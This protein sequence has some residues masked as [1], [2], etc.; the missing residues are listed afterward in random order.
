MSNSDSNREQERIVAELLERLGRDELVDIDALVAEHP[1]CAADL[2]RAHSDWICVQEGLIR[3]PEQDPE[4]T[5]GSVVEMLLD[6]LAARSL[7]DSRY[8]LRGELG[9]G[10]M[11]AV[12]EVWDRDLHRSLAMKVIRHAGVVR[13]SAQ[14]ARIPADRVARFIEE[15]QVSSQLSHPSV[16]P[17]HDLG[18]DAE[19]RLYFTMPIIEGRTFGSILETVHSEQSD[20]SQT[21]ALG[22]IVRTC[23]AMA[24][25]HSRGV[26][27][28]D[29]KPANLMIGPFG[30]T[31]VMDWGLAL[32]KQ[33]EHRPV[34]SERRKQIDSEP[35]SPLLTAT[36]FALG[37]A[38]YMPPEQVDGRHDTIDKPADIYAIGAMLYEL[39]TGT[40]PYLDDQDLQ[41]QSDV[42][43]AVQFGPPTPVRKLRRDVAE[44][45]ESICERAMAR[46]PSRRYPSMDS[47]AAD[48]NAYLENRVVQAHATGPLAEFRKW[49]GRNRAVALTA[50]ALL[51]VMLAAGFGQAW[52]ERRAKEAIA[53][54][55]DKADSA[56]LTGLR[57]EVSVLGPV[58]DDSVP[59]MERWLGQAR[60]LVA[61]RAQH[62]ATLESLRADR[63]AD[64]DHQDR[65]RD[66]WIARLERFLVELD[67]FTGEATGGSTIRTVEYRLEHARQLSERSLEAPRDAW[68]EAI[69]MISDPKVC[70]QYGR[71]QLKP[72]LGL[73]PIGRDPDS[74]LFEFWQV[75]SGAQPAR[76]PEG[77]L[78]IE[79][80]SGLVL[81]LIPGGSVWIGTQTAYPDEPNYDPD[82]V[83]DGD[84]GIYVPTLVTLDPFFLSKYEMTQGQWRLWAGLNP[85]YYQ[86]SESFENNG[87]HFGQT[88]PVETVSWEQALQ[89]LQL[90]GLTLPTEGQWEFACR[91][92]KQ[93]PWWCGDQKECLEGAVNLIDQTSA[94][95]G[96]DNA[97]RQEW[98]ELNDGYATTAPVDSL[99][100]NPLGLHH[101][102]GNVFEWTRESG[103]FLY[104]DAAP[105]D[106]DGLVPGELSNK[107]VIRGGSFRYSVRHAT[108]ARRGVLPPFDR[109][110]HT[111]VRP[112]RPV[113]H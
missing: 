51:I 61:R 84:P 82:A 15:A 22:V 52:Q 28:R 55:R 86:E 68:S 25:A 42:L 91:A 6:R 66:W 5:A 27:H 101:M 78:Q 46:E 79:S 35:Q 73:V 9:R 2:R 30:E 37:S 62:V 17:I 94:R 88:H 29:L 13:G 72:Q 43:R 109:N 92:G 53:R 57:E 74:G 93:T 71:L 59:V 19:G 38:P 32:L 54:E 45:L 36:G 47:L 58:H 85:A 105:R 10:G 39:L 76:D 48:L 4:S 95:Y 8:E 40:A 110:A 3:A 83:L 16:V 102:L 65:L 97:N 87:L 34:H 103:Y 81:V 104:E 107:R 89:Q 14:Q 31:Y 98:P 100:P 90:I 64:P 1:E 33:G 63:E 99:R 7:A 44:E 60:E 26:V 96:L 75:L 67:A 50:S 49:F 20:W 108:S 113:E 106:G 70:P 11:G 69:A 12:F 23:E 80:D 112:A 18:L 111:G 21:R 77:R 41:S 56:L 24:Y